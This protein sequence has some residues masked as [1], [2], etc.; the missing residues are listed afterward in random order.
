MWMLEF[1]LTF[2]YPS[3]YWGFSQL[4]LTEEGS[5][6]PQQVLIWIFP[7][8]QGIEQSTSASATTY[9][10]WRRFIIWLVALA[11]FIP[12]ITQNNISSIFLKKDTAFA[13]SRAVVYF[14]NW[15]E[16][17]YDKYLV[18]IW[19]KGLENHSFIHLSSITVATRGGI[20]Q[21]ILY[22]KL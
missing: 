21:Q 17:W 6:E 16:T 20:F 9:N 18:R 13:F 3:G 8:L 10:V 12:W 15:Q 19:K 2:L 5:I 14:Y 4:D 7:E 22:S 11:F 1:W